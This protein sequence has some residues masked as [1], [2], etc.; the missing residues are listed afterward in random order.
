M[1]RLK[2]VL[3]LIAALGMGILGSSLPGRN[4]LQQ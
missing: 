4:Q 1:N 2:N 3:L